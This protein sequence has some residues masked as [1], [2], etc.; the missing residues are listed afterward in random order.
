MDTEIREL[1]EEAM[2]PDRVKELERQ[3]KDQRREAQEEGERIRRETI[4]SCAISGAVAA[5]G[6]WDPE[7]LTLLLERENLDVEDGKVQGLEETL[8]RL[9]SLRP[10][11]FRDGGD[12][13]HF[14]AAAL[15]RG[16]LPEEERVAAKYRDNPWY[17][18]R[19]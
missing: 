16:L 12:R 19:G 3:L 5:S 2:E 17:R 14:A 18:R 10:Y 6:T 7:V 11:L 8:E 9:R 4:R 1:F 13:P 15:D